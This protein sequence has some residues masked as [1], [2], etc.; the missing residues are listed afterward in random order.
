[1]IV[2]RPSPSDRGMGPSDLVRQQLEEL[3]GISHPQPLLCICRAHLWSLDQLARL[4]KSP[5]PGIISYCDL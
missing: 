5:A 3:A 1:M 2:V 4:V